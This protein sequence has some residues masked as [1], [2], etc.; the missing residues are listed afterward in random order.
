MQAGSNRETERDRER[1]HK[2]RRKEER[3]TEYVLSHRVFVLALE[4]DL[5][6]LFLAVE[7]P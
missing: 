4:N 7:S 1:H 5:L 2:K 6:P 3:R